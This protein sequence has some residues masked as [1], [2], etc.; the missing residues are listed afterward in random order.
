MEESLCPRWRTSARVYSDAVGAVS[1]IAYPSTVFPGLSFVIEAISAPGASTSCTRNRY[2]DLFHLRTQQ[3]IVG[4]SDGFYKFRCEMIVNGEKVRD[5]RHTRRSRGRDENR[6]SR[7]HRSR[8]RRRPRISRSSAPLPTPLIGV[9][10]CI[11]RGRSYRPANSVVA[12][13]LLPP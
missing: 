3:T 2:F 7:Y 6:N 4:A 11:N 9:N 5:V 13:E 8:G 1:V 10:R 12:D